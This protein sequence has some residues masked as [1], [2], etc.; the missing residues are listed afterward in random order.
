MAGYRENFAST[1]LYRPACN[2][3]TTLTGLLWLTYIP[4]FKNTV[5]IESDV[6]LQKQT[7]KQLREIKKVK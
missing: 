4:S 2:L 6:T 7:C 3:V 5:S 1:I